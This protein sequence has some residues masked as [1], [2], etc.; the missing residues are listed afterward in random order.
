MTIFQHMREIDSMLDNLTESQQAAALQMCDIQ[1]AGGTGSRAFGGSFNTDGNT[2]YSELH[3][4]VFGNVYQGSSPF[5]IGQI[6]HQGNAGEIH[7]DVFGN[8]KVGDS[9]F[10][11]GSIPVNQHHGAGVLRT[12]P[13]GNIY[14]GN[15]PFSCG[16]IDDFYLENP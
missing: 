1:S 5:A 11:V 2:P 15:S 13:F 12:D 9:P 3:S 7:S 10:C 8:V 14:E 4:D 16:E 6:D